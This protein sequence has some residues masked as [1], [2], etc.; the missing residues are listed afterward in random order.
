MN[1]PAEIWNKVLKIL[2]KEFTATTMETWFGATSAVDM[3][4]DLLVISTP[5]EMCRDIITKKYS[6]H[7][8]AA[9]FELFSCDFNLLIITQ[10]ET[11]EYV[12][13]GKTAAYNKEAYGNYTFSNFVVG[14]S[15]KFA[16]SAAKSVAANPAGPYNPLFIYGDSGLGK[17]HLLCAIA[18]EIS[19]TKPDFRIVYIKGD[20]FTNELVA[21]IQSGKNVEF[22]NKY[23]YAD[24]FI[25]DDIQFI[26]GK[27]ETQQEFFNTFNT[28]YEADKQIVLASDRPPKE[29]HLLED[30]LRSRFEAGLLADIEP[31]EL[32]TRMA[33]LRS[34]ASQL[35]LS[36]PDA[37]VQYVAENL[38]LNVRQ[39][40]GGV[41]KIMALTE[42]MESDVNP[43]IVT[44]AV[45]DMIKTDVSLK[46]SASVIIE[47]VAQY[48][49]I[50]ENAIRGKLRTKET[51][52]ARQTAM[53]LIRNM[54]DMPL[55]DIGAE[56]GGRDHST[57]L[58]SIKKI[59]KYV[60]SSPDFSNALKDIKTNINNRK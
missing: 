26:A 18:N 55:D 44:K 5:T 58:N 36:L 8:K 15:N 6:Q 40:E 4:D 46:P 34:K 37:V 20:D 25:V 10:D 38:S 19:R 35:G 59:E 41:K 31:P 13:R 22:R 24:L 14:N 57:V 53:Y 16:Y 2:S 17:T 32:E 7:I 50:D 39:L 23:R 1:S 60:S 56:F 47:E 11:T 33:I 52:F 29:M 43:S 30:R 48:Y 12:N 42:V 9:L 3:T 21:A 27:K 28:L 51:T 54:T 49:L 45:Q